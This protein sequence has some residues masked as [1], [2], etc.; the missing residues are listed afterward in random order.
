M[1]DSTPNNI[2]KAIH[3]HF[4]EAPEV[5]EVVN[6]VTSTLTLDLMV[7]IGV[8]TNQ[9]QVPVPPEALHMVKRFDTGLT[10]NEFYL[11]NFAAI[12]S[13]LMMV[14]IKFQTMMEYMAAMNSANKP[15]VSL[16]EQSKAVYMT[17]FDTIT[18]IA[19][20]WKGHTFALEFD[21]KFRQLIQLDAGMTRMFESLSK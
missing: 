8:M 17:Q 9:T 10:T 2:S 15:P 1:T 12:R 18:L 21:R 4:S 19:S 20:L 16:V 5:H 13:S 6:Y 11:Q 14:D 3:D 7:A